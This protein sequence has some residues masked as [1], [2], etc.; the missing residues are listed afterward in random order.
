MAADL[1][2]D[3]ETVEDLVALASSTEIGLL[4]PAWQIRCPHC[5]RRVDL[6]PLLAQLSRDGECSCPACDRSIEHPAALATEPR[7]RLAD[8]ADAAVAAHQESERAKPVMRA[9]VLC[10]LP[11]ELT[12]VRA[13]MEACG[14]VREEV[15]TGGEIYLTVTFSGEHVTWEVFAACSERS[16]SAAAA[17]V[18]N[19]I[20]NFTPQIALFVGVAGGI[21]GKVALGDVVAATTVFDYDQGKETPA[22]YEPRELQLHS[23]FDLTQRAL[24][25]ASSEEWKRRIDSKHADAQATFT[26]HVEPI[27]AGGKV[28]A[29]GSSPT[30]QL[31]AT[32]APRAVA[33]ETEGAGFLAAVRRFQRVSGIVIRGISDLLD[34]KHISDAGGSQPIGAAR[35]TAFAFTLLDRFRPPPA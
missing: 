2:L 12:A 5:G 25:V 9:A 31:I 14:T 28:I 34:D 19:A 6:E 27:A 16:N 20:N 35:A 15:I 29:A 24:H 1:E 8:E 17:S 33:V 26:A 22:G 7:Y 3:E 21:A 11:V 4:C 23:A 10:A 32:I 13:Q 30:T 18:A